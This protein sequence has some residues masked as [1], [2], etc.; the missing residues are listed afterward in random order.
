MEELEAILANSPPLDATSTA[1]SASASDGFGL[2]FEALLQIVLTQL[3]FQDPLQ[4][5]ENFE[6]VSQLAQFSQIQ[7]AETTNDRLLTL[8]QSDAAS[9]AV[10][11]LGQ[12]V[13]IPAGST[14]LSGRVT[15]IAFE[16]GEPRISLET[17]T[18]QSVSNISL[19]NISE[20]REGQ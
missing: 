9:Q 18:G 6:F 14:V 10:G 19:N 13:D 2:Q 16:N 11:L 1:G 4:P 12:Q 15:S 8:L 7:Q 5:I 20:I 17:E 3:Q